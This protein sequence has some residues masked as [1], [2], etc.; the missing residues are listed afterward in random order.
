MLTS[1]LAFRNS[2]TGN[3]YIVMLDQAKD[4][5][6]NNY[7]NP[8]LSLNEVSACVNLSPSHFS[9]IFSRETGETFKEY[10]TGVRIDKA[11]ELLRTTSLKSFEITYKIGYSDPHYFS[12]VFKKHT[13]LSPKQFRWRGQTEQ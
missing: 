6:D 8:D 9:T 3:Q 13:G 10:L 1:A 5:I 2:Q 7:A 12:V 4:Y 11:K